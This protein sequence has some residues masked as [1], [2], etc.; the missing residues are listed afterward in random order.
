MD[1]ETYK[2]IKRDMG[3]DYYDK[4]YF[5]LHER[6]GLI[7]NGRNED[8]EDE[9]IGTDNQWDELEKLLEERP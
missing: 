3:N 4:E 2:H 8:G 6:A 5:K 7:Y 1:G 9:W